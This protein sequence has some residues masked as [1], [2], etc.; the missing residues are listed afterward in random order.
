MMSHAH[1]Q[2]PLS[3]YV[4]TR[5]ELRYTY[6][7]YMLM[8]SRDVANHLT[9]LNT[10]PALSIWLCES[11]MSIQLSLYVCMHAPLRDA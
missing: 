9:K 2:S 3:T 1:C 10:R 11:L 7:L 5:P 6:I 8:H 4:Y